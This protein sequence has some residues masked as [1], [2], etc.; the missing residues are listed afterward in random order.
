M[1][2]LVAKNGKGGVGEIDKDMGW[3][4]EKN[5]REVRERQFCLSTF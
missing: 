1:G 5:G 4:G 2:E 3:A